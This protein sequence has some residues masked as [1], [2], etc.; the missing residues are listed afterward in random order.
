MKVVGII[1]VAALIAYFEISP[2]ANKKEIKD[3][4][5]FSFLLLI[6]TVLS[7]M[8]AIGVPIPNPLDGVTKVLKPV[9]NFI[10]GLLE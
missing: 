3:L 5:V 10:L 1:I 4:W 9:T 8:L 7:I 6:G 2:M